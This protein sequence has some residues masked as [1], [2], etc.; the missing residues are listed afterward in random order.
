MKTCTTKDLALI[1]GC[2]VQYIGEMVKNGDLPTPL[3]QNQHDVI[4]ACKAMLDKA[5]EEAVDS[6]SNIAAEKLKIA[7]YTAKKIQIEVAEAMKLLISVKMVGEIL[8]EIT[9]LIRDQFQNIPSRISPIL[10]AE[11]DSKK[12]YEILE[13]EI[14]QV[15]ETLSLAFEKLQIQEDL[16]DVN[17]N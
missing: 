4:K 2:S 1:Y 6:Q 7:K 13:K 10:A 8:W 3:K 17:K 11:K 15:L 12:I 5:R 9:R 14:R 16:S